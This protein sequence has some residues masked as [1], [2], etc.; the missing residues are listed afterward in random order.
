M[1]KEN[2]HEMDIQSY[3][4]FLNKTITL[5]KASGRIPKDEVQETIDHLI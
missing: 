3:A 4:I 2:R 5:T 1:Y